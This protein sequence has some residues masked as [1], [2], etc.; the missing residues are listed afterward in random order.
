MSEATIT[1][2]LG[3]ITAI[4]VTIDLLLGQNRTDALAE[5][6]ALLR[7]MLNNQNGGSPPADKPPQ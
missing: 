1:A 3:L 7:E 5:L 6:R 4:L 2:V